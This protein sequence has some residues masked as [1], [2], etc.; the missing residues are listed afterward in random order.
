MLLLLGLW[1]ALAAFLLLPWFKVQ[2]LGLR[3]LGGRERLGT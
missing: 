3:V 1:G 2:S